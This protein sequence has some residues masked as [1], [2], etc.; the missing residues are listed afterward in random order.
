NSQ[1]TVVES[2]LGVGHGEYFNNV[3]SEVVLGRNAVLDHYRVCQEGGPGMH[4][5]TQQAHLHGSSNFRSHAFT[6]GGALVRNDV[7]ATL[8]AEGAE[9]T[10]NGLYVAAGRQHVD[11]HTRIDHAQAH[12]NSHETYQGVLDGQSRGVFNGKILVR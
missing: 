1:A 9:C 6:L 4:V 3:V 10:L 7:N 8:A 11:N 12:C 2:Y 5:A